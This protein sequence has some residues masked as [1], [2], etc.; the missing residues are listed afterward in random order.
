LCPSPNR[1]RL[2]ESRRMRKSEHV[3]SKG[4]E[5]IQG[6]GRKKLKDRDH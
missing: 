1:I 5:C 6:L 3:A 2:T 4:Q